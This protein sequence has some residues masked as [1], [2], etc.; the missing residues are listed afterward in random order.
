MR[1]DGRGMRDHSRKLIAGFL[2]RHPKD[3]HILIAAATDT[4]AL[5]ALDAVREHKRERNVA[6][7]GQDCIPEALKEMRRRGS[8]FIGSVSHQAG[9]YG[10]KLI[11]LGLALLRG[12]M[13]QPYNYVPHKLITQATLSSL[14]EEQLRAV[15]PR[16]PE[17]G[18]HAKK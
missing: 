8:P 11:H 6:I 13:V 4:S 1:M 7:I 17:K 10:E 16:L 3:R 9:S 12:Q 14:E 5:G 15:P 18:P 2:Q